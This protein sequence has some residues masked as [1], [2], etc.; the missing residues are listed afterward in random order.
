MSLSNCLGHNTAECSMGG[1]GSIT[2]MSMQTAIYHIYGLPQDD[3]SKY[4][5][6]SGQLANTDNCIDAHFIFTHIPKNDIF[7]LVL[8]MSLGP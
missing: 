8:V 4:F 6:T 1:K 7:S 3:N 5:V 2:T